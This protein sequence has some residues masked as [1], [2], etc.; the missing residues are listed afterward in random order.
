M[1]LVPELDYSVRWHAFQLNPRAPLQTSKLQ[2]Y[3]EKFGRSKE[4]TL[5]MGESM[6]E[7]F[8][9]AGLPFAFTDKGVTGN[10]TT[11]HRLL[12]FAATVGL[13]EQNALAEELFR[14]YFTEQGH[15]NDHALLEELAA[16]AGIDRAAA[17]A[18][19]EDPNAQL[20]EVKR[21]L[22]GARGVNGVPHFKISVDG[23]RPLE[24]SGAQPVDM[25]QRVF[26]KV[27]GK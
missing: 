24:V 18:V 27:A 15:L 2:A 21:E 13:K 1:R 4:Q 26:A 20:E 17:R 3:M 11:A 19:L 12:S 9:E 23:F 6:R 5:A 16:T 10:T 22:A 14:I 25:F 7:R 8:A